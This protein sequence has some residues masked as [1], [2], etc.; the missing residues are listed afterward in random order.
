MRLHY[1]NRQDFEKKNNIQHEGSLSL[2]MYE[3][4]PDNP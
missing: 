3:D 1:I 2:K 4:L